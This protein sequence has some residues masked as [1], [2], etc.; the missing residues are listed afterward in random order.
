[1]RIPDSMEANQK[2]SDYIVT[3]KS[4]DGRHLFVYWSKSSSCGD[5]DIAI[6]V[7]HMPPEKQE[8]DDSS[9]DSSDDSDNSDNS[10]DDSDCSSKPGRYIPQ[11]GF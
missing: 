9:D 6:F 8:D 1:M 4:A 10:S 5:I 11:G 3:I 7:I 2:N